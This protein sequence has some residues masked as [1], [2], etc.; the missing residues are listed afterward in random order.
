MQERKLVSGKFST[1]SV[2]KLFNSFLSS[3]ATRKKLCHKFSRRR[4]RRCRRRRRRRGA[5]FLCEKSSLKF[6][7]QKRKNAQG[8]SI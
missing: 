5:P 3:S 8:R 4:R 7:D 1:R 2:K 6:A